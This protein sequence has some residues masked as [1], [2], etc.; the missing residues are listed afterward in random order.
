MK[1]DDETF[2]RWTAIPLAAISTI[3]VAISLGQGNWLG[4]AGWTIPAALFVL[5]VCYLWHR[6]FEQKTNDRNIAAAR[7]REYTATNDGSDNTNAYVG[8]MQ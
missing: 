1:L 8:P 2:L 6:R 3:G 7:G 5:A 4:A